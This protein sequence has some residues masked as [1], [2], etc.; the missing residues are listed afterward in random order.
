MQIRLLGPVVAVGETGELDLG[1][2]KQRTLAALLASHAGSPVSVDR[3]IDALWG[4]TPPE[5]AKHSL[6]TYISNPVA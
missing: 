3:C 4:E 5:G 2:R 6:Q 1:G